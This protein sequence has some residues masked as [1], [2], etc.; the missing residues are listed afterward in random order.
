MKK[1][2][3]IALVAL[4]T[5]VACKKE[6]NNGDTSNPSN[7]G[8][9]KVLK[10]IIETKSGVTTTHSLAYDANKRLTSIRTSDN[11]EVISFTYDGNG[12]VTK[13]ENKEGDER[14][15]FEYSYNNNVPVSGTFKS[16]EKDEAQ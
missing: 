12:N 9:S 16:F 6:K 11:S 1:Y 13:I 2:F 14:S 10:K 8:S 5:V 3:L 4:T 7:P 15:V